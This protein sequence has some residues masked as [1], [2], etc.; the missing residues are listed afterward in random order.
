M[1]SLRIPQRFFMIHPLKFAHHYRVTMKKI[2]IFILISGLFLIGFANAE[3]SAYR[4]EGISGDV[5]QNVQQRLAIAEQT[6]ANESDFITHAPDDIKKALAPFGY[7]KATVTVQLEPHIIFH[8]NLGPPLKISS[9]DIK[10][11]GMGVENEELQQYIKQFPLKSGQIF[12]ASDY[13]KA[14]N[15]LFDIANRQGYLKAVLEKKSIQINLQQNTATIFLHLNTGPRYYFGHV[16][17]GPNPY[18]NSF[19][20]R[21]NSIKENEPYSSEKL[22][23][24]Q[25]QLR[26][27][28][29]FQ[30][31][32]TH[33][34]FEHTMQNKVPVQVDIQTPK[35]QRYDIGI[36]YG[37]YT[38]ARLTLGSEF[39]RVTDTGQHVSAQLK[40]SS[41]LSR[42]SAKYYIPGTNP[43]TDQYSL[44][45][46]IQYFLPKNGW[47][48]SQAL[49]ATF[50]KKLPEWQRNI[51]LNYLNERY[52]VINDNTHQ[53]QIFYPN[54]TFSR[55]RADDLFYP[56][57]GSMAYLS[58][59]GASQTVFSKT[60]FFQTEARGKYIFS[61]TTLS[62]IILRGDLGY[63]AV[64][65]L[66]QLPLSL[67]YFAGGINSVRGYPYNS[68]GPGKYLE[69]GSAEF[70]H[71]IFGNW[72]GALFYDIGNASNSFNGQFNR[73]AGGGIVYQSFLGPMQFYVGRALSKPGKPLSFE[74]N[75]GPDF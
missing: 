21:F 61:P 8:I 66:D 54:L 42:L 25:E 49:S 16:L 30:A 51:S 44:G 74:F 43:L 27:S 18:A 57:F 29:Y 47:S 60:S 36:G 11:V 3:Q 4:I 45:G 12:S 37:T 69:V 33:P 14:K 34:D 10:I 5:L 67:R 65:N 15:K 39:R 58:V 19:L 2:K 72:N 35:S 20:Q 63:T 46:N 70:Q 52:R 1:N 40:L 38:G 71:K 22:L 75:I 28:N 9:V 24:F 32:N 50:E 7:F 23:K 41:V 53:S 31:V 6:S 17:Y 56:R 13:E 55:T 59:Q 48:F 73:G 68:I 62:R 64:E 26:S